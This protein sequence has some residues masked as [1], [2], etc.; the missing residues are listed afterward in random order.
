MEMSRNNGSMST[1]DVDEPRSS[2]KGFMHNFTYLILQLNSLKLLNY[3]VDRS[4]EDVIQMKVNILLF[5]FGFTP[6]MFLL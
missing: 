3:F 2:E 6:T 1:N 5:C 4:V